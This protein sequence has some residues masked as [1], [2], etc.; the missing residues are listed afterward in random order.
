MIL[1]TS[2]IFLNVRQL[3]VRQFTPNTSQRD[4]SQLGTRAC[5]VIF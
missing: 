4:E 5:V 1:V 2:Q 3:P